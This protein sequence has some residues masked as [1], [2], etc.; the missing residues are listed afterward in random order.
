MNLKYRKDSL[1]GLND[2]EIMTR[3]RIINS[4]QLSD[5]AFLKKYYCDRDTLFNICLPSF[6][7]SKREKSDIKLISLYLANLK[8][9]MNLI[10]NYNED[11]TNNSSQKE[12][13]EQKNKYL[14]LLKYISE[15][16]VYES[17]SNKR[18]IMRY[19]DSGDKFYLILYGTVSILIPVKI[20]ISMTFYEYCQYIATLLLYKEFELAKIVIRENKHIYSLEIPDIKYIIYFFNKEEE[21]N[22]SIYKNCSIRG[23]KSEKNINSK[24]IRSPKKKTLK[25][26]LRLNSIKSFQDEDKIL[27]EEHAQKINKF[28][29]IC[30]TP[31]QYKLYEET[32]NKKQDIEKDDGIELTSEIYINRLKSYK[33]NKDYNENIM[34][35]KAKKKPNTSRRRTRS[36]TTLHHEIENQKDDNN[37]YFLNANKNLVYIYEYQEIIQLESGDMFGDMALSN[38]TSKRTAS[39]ISASDCHFGSLNKDIP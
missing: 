31:E 17:F 36:K 19:G 39:I 12:K 11:N 22:N 7:K 30:L 27:K 37:T 3:I 2:R 14:K 32:K 28:M 6:K 4:F 9:F 10:Q 33:Y 34:R 21:E 26:S 18:L 23:I 20:N 25:I 8:K 5:E 24:I 35:E 13:K 38:S 1:I 15:N 16:I 29:K